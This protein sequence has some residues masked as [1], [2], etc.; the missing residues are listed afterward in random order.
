M[1]L[2]T[3]YKLKSNPNYLIYLR[4]NSQWYKY[5]NR[6]PRYFKNF[7]EE[8]KEKLSLRFS[9]KLSNTLKTIEILE[10]VFSSFK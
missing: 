4:R 5:L 7:E 9:D 1:T 10:N 2:E 6:N 3:Q 8:A